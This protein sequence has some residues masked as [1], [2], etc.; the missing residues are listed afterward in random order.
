VLGLGR[1]LDLV[2]LGRLGPDVG[3]HARGDDLVERHRL[4]GGGL[5]D[6]AVP[7]QLVDPRRGSRVGER[8]A[9]RHGHHRL[10]RPRRGRFD[11]TDLAGLGLGLD[12]PDLGLRRRRHRLGR[13]IR[14]HVRRRILGHR[15]P[16]R[17]RDLM[18]LDPLGQAEQAS[19]RRV[20]L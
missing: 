8:A 5:L 4:G 3:R 11:G 20:Q 13:A 14:H 6:V 17:T 2:D 19:D 12:R 7:E 1:G 18:A 10:D 9:G 15:R 16:E